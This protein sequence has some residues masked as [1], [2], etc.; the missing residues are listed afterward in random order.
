MVMSV[1]EKAEAFDRIVVA[2][3]AHIDA[4]DAYNARLEFVRAERQRGNWLNVDPEFAASTSAQKEFHRVVNE[5]TDLALRED[6]GHEWHE[7]VFASMKLRVC[8][9]CGFILNED[10]PNKPCPGVVRVELRSD[11]TEKS[12]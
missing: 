12:G 4:V 3:K 9:N 5:T 1:E 11:S 7:R 2:R 6:G 10:K 8:M